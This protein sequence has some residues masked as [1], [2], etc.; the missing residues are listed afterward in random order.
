ML[1]SAILTQEIKDYSLDGSIGKVSENEPF[2][3][4]IKLLYGQILLR[5]KQD[6]EAKAVL[7]ELLKD[8]N[9]LENI[10]FLARVLINNI[11]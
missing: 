6:I 11:K 2:Y 7:T 10:S 4:T 1:M 8:N 5:D 3:G 9:V